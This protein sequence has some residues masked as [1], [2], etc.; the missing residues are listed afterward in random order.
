VYKLA[1]LGDGS[2]GKTSLTVSYCHNHFVEC[3]DPTIEDC[4]RR[5]RMVDEEACLIEILD[6]AGQEEFS[7]LRDQWIRESEGYVLVYSI[8]SRD[9]FV[10]IE[11]ITNAIRRV[12]EMDA[13][14]I[15]LIL[16]ANKADLGS[17][18][19]VT[20]EE[21]QQ[22]AKA[23]GAQFVEASAKTREGVEEVF[24]RG[25]RVIQQLRR[26]DQSHDKKKAKSLIKRKQACAIL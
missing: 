25:V 3:Y 15:P 5:Q 18:R 24:D 17:R 13:H 9:S 8:T 19:Q 7:A 4:Y 6:T 22:L 21:G 11:S 23:I 10:A 2:V 12:V 16:V 1:V 20:R 14:K 26:K